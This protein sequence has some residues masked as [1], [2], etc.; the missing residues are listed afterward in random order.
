[1]RKRDV[2]R[3]AVSQCAGVIVHRRGR[4]RRYRL[5]SPRALFPVMPPGLLRRRGR[6][7]RVDVAANCEERL[8]DDR[9]TP[10]SPSAFAPST[11][12]CCCFA[13]SWR[14]IVHPSCP[15]WQSFA[16]PAQ[17]ARSG[18]G[19]IQPSVQSTQRVRLS[20]AETLPLVPALH[21]WC[22]SG[23]AE[24]QRGTSTPTLIRR[25]PATKARPPVNP[26]RPPRQRTRTS[27]L[28]GCLPLCAPRQAAA[29]KQ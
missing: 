26:L 1:M 28:Y 6:S 15:A 29:R 7:D 27:S 25:T 4:G 2:L 8:V 13:G 3:L 18:A 16:A 23:F 9:L 19:S 17:S 5:P 12:R 10:V 14:L 21:Y 22:R 24:K 20:F 11:T